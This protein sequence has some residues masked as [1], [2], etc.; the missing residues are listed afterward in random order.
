MNFRLQLVVLLAVV[1]PVRSFALFGVG[2]IVFDPTAYS[3]LLQT[4][5]QGEAQLNALGSVVG[6]SQEQLG[7]LKN[8]NTAIGVAKPGLNPKDLTAGQ[9]A[10]LSQGLGVDVSG[11]LALVYKKDGPMAGALD[12]FMGT[13]LDSFRSERAT[14][15]TAFANFSSQSALSAL[16][17]AAGLN[18]A[19]IEFAR[20]LARMSA[21][22]R[23]ANSAAISRGLSALAS[24][25]Y[26][27]SGERRRLAIQA[28]AD[29]SQQA[30]TRAA[31][32][33]NVN[34]NAAAH[35]ELLASQARL[36]T[37]AAQHENE[38]SEALFQQGESM[39]ASMTELDARRA[40][41]ELAE[42]LAARQDGDVY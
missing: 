13:T 37:L 8:I 29:L 19:E 21:G 18:S 36:Q 17:T 35:N 6:L 23:R 24:A 41:D 38:A 14:P 16:G 34:E 30:A 2:D 15:W 7:S 4:Y 10:A 20:T 1:A 3:Q 9:I 11:A 32:A 26:A 31:Q 33:T 28:E 27:A 22:E 42:R 12:V 25:R 40:R 5:A 39:Q